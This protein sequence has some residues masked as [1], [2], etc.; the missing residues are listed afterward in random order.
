MA[1]LTLVLVLA[2]M[3]GIIS[4]HAR[5]ARQGQA[6]VH[7]KKIENLGKITMLVG[8]LI[9]ILAVLVFH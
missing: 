1:K 3:I 9:V 5:K 4:G 6:E 2:A 8:I 7:L